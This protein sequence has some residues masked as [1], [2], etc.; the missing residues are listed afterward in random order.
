MHI[1]AYE[2]YGYA[3]YAG[4]GFMLSWLVIEMTRAYLPGKEKQEQ[5][6]FGLTE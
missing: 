6:D 4:T 3:L 5:N 1:A 2:F